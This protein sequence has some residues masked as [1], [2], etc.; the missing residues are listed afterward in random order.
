MDPQ[1]R[2]TTATGSKDDS[3]LDPDNPAG[4]EGGV[5][6]VSESPDDPARPICLTPEPERPTE[7]IPDGPAQYSLCF[8]PAT[9][10]QAETVAGEVS[11]TPVEDVAAG[12]RD[13]E[14]EP[15][16]VGLWNN[17]P[18][19]DLLGDD[20]EI[21]GYDSLL[22]NENDL[23]IYN[24]IVKLAEEP[25]K[26]TKVNEHI[27]TIRVGYRDICQRSGCC[28]RAL[29]RAWP[30]LGRLGVVVCKERHSDRIENLY[31]VRMPEWLVQQYRQLGCTHYRVLPKGILQPFRPRSEAEER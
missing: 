29:G 28:K 20:H 1:D 25:G 24:A 17:V 15:E 18:T 8:E 30:R 2:A 9:L 3:S 21:S 5:D 12:N 27:W 19:W 14:P 26:G 7:N 16:A 13:S 4:E 6:G 31:L 10:E 23:K 11:A 22:P